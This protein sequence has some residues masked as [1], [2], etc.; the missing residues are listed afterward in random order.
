[1][2]RYQFGIFIYALQCNF[3]DGNSGAGKI[4]AHTHT[5]RGERQ[6]LDF[7]TLP[8]DASP[9][10]RQFLHAHVFRQSQ[11]CSGLNA[12]TISGQTYLLPHVITYNKYCSKNKKQEFTQASN[13]RSIRE[14]AGGGHSPVKN[15]GMLV[16]KFELNS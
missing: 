5:T 9:R 12:V 10:G 6:K 13:E 3:D 15:M 16:G 2:R 4:H 11:S 7:S 8:R 14:E 1:M